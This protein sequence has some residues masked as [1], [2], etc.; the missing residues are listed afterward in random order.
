M[1]QQENMDSGQMEGKAVPDWIGFVIQNLGMYFFI[2][3]G[4]TLP[5]LARLV[6]QFRSYREKNEI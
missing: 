2:G 3:I 6:Y 5:C 1:V 4:E